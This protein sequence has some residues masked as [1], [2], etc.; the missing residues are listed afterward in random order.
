MIDHYEIQSH[1]PGGEWEHVG[2]KYPDYKWEVRRPWYFLGLIRCPRITNREAALKQ[3]AC[4]LVGLLA[5]SWT[6]KDG[7]C[8]RIILW[9]R[10]LFGRLWKVQMIEA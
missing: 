5:E 8:V 4:D 1:R 2:N 9:C 3:A 6:D 7:E 10:G